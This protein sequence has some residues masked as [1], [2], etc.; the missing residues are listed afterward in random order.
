MPGRRSR[1]I[2]AGMDTTN[3]ASRTTA[4]GAPHRVVIVGGG[5]AGLQAAR[6]ASRHDLDVTL[7]DRRNF[8]LFSPL[9]YQVA[10]GSLGPGE[11]A[12]PLRSVF[13]RRR[14]VRVVLA[15]VSDLDLDGRRVL[16]RHPERG[17][18]RGELAYDSLVVAAGS[19]YSY[20]GHDAWRPHAPALK[21]LESALDIRRRI[22]GAFEAAETEPDPGRRAALLTFVV[23]GAGPTGVELA[24]QIA[25]IAR[26]TLRRDFRTI[27]PRTARV[28][29]V[30]A[31]GRVLGAMRPSLSEKAAR[32]LRGL[33]VTPLPGHL[34]THV[35][36]ASV[37]VAAAGRAE[38]IEARTVLWAAGVEGSPLGAAL[39]A[40]RDAAGRVLVGP[41]LTLRGRPDVWVLGDMARVVGPD[42][43]EV[44]LPGTAPVA[45]QQGRYAGR[46]IAARARGRHVRPF[47]YRDKGDVATIGRVRAVADLRGVRL[48]G[49]LAWLL[50]LG[51]HLWYLVGFGRR[52]VTVIRW[53]WT[54]LTRGRDSRL[55]TGV[56]APAPA[57]APQPER[58]IRAA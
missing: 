1:S 54:F 5:F 28:L 39:G 40:E 32:Q 6:A 49:T 50:W 55:I 51:I 41:D 52:L 24:G 20:F 15:E 29:L 4:P 13:R 22:L 57:P 43:R 10:T 11:I 3:R 12:V 27:D 47:A 25:E 26:D 23:V 17:A 42:G 19:Q 48:S 44:A 33:G 35:D 31:G 37:T 38:R 56:P 8:H 16:L 45:M 58:Y 7:V 34:V 53:T 30:E 18:E 14:N 2:V 46:A 36:A 9:L 21:T